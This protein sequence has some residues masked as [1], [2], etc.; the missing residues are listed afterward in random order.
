MKTLANRLGVS[1]SYLREVVR[2]N[3]GTSL[4]AL[5]ETVRLVHALDLIV[6]G[7]GQALYDISR[8]VGYLSARTFREAFKRRLG[9]SPSEFIR[10]LDEKD[11]RCR[12]AIAELRASLQSARSAVM[13]GIFRQIFPAKNDRFGVLTKRNLRYIFR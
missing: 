7:R 9:M 12:K 2:M 1:N 11:D 10:L 4:G 6:D 3:C 13:P 8:A 5:I